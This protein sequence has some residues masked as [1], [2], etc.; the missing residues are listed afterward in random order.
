MLQ[1]GDERLRDA[2]T[3]AAAASL[4]ASRCKKLSYALY[5]LGTLIILFGRASKTLGAK[6][7]SGA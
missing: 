2:A 1:F 7:K 4:L 5:V 3:E 6:A